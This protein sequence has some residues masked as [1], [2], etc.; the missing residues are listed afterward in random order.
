MSSTNLWSN[1]SATNLTQSLSQSTTS[2]I[3]NIMA[4]IPQNLTELVEHPGIFLQ[5]T[6][7]K[8]IS[9]AFVW[10]ALFITC[11]QVFNDYS[12]Y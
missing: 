2:P 11:H 7:A 3:H 4:N 9:G 5:S 1:T 6:S 10:I 12:Y 8:A